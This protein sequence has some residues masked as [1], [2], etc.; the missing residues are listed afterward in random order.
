MLQ[1]F[2]DRTDDVQTVALIAIKIL[3][4]DILKDDVSVTYWIQSYRELLDIW[5]LWEHRAH[6][7]INLSQVHTSP[8][9]TKSIY[10]S[11]P[12]CG[13][14][15]SQVS[16]ESAERNRTGA[17][18]YAN[19]V[20]SCPSCLKPL[21]RC[22]LC[23]L[24]MGTTNASCFQNKTGYVGSSWQSKPFAK[25]FSWCQSCRHGGHTEHL[26]QWFSTHAECPVAQCTC[27]C[28][29]L[30][31]PLSPLNANGDGNY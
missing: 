11:C 19:K 7:D 20:S 28:F 17:N 23:M 4:K 1:S 22:S 9:H 5:R 31:E 3:P 12:Y 10:L 25:W 18:V 21:P 8:K 6:L 16:P 26:T 29:D 30:D 13:K 14:N 15:A 2:L 24:H 27:K